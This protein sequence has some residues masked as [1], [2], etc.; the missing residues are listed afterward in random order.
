MEYFR[1]GEKKVMKK[2]FATTLA[3]CA[4]SSVALAHDGATAKTQAYAHPT[5]FKSQAQTLVDADS[6]YITGGKIL[7]MGKNKVTVGNKDNVY[8]KSWAKDV[9]DIIK[10][11]QLKSGYTTSFN[12]KA[13]TLRS[14][15]ATILAE[16][17]N[18]QLRL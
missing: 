8:V 6:T 10:D 4:L 7:R 5:L 17:L 14:E 1:I 15:V 11:S 2:L 13:P 16:G 12:P 18:L 9:L 3:M